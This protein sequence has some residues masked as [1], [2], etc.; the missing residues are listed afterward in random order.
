MGMILAIRV[1]AA[2]WVGEMRFGGRTGK[3]M[4]MRS[5]VLDSHLR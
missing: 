1:R 3:G 2:V 4:R 5:A